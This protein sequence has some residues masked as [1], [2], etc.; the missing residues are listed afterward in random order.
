M[1]RLLLLALALTA[2]MDINGETFRLVTWHRQAGG[3]VHATTD[4]GER[5]TVAISE[6]RGG[7]S[8]GKRYWHV[9]GAAWDGATMTGR[10]M[11]GVSDEWMA[12]AFGVEVWG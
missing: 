11:L 9:T 6:G 7:V 5:V 1:T 4:Q 2:D 12:K 8:V 3:E 10:A